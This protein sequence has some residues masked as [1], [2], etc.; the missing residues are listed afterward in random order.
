MAKD[1]RAALNDIDVTDF[2]TEELEE[3]AVDQDKKLLVALRTGL[4]DSG[5]TRQN[6]VQMVYMMFHLKSNGFDTTR[7]TWNRHLPGGPT[8]GPARTSPCGS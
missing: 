7:P 6:D 2:D 1:M 5:L 3:Q 8:T 4:Q